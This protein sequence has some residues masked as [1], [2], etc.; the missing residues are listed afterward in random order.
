MLHSLLTSSRVKLKLALLLGCVAALT[1]A[2]FAIGVRGRLPRV[3]KPKTSGDISAQTRPRSGPVQLVQF[4]IY[5]VAIYPQEARVQKG[6]VA[7]SIED[8]TGSSSGLIIDRVEGNERARAGVVNR[9]MN[10]LRVRDEFFLPP[11][12]YEVSD[13]SRPDNRAELIVEP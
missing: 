13:A 2:V 1:T 6:R 12:H 10:R 7:V 8:L 5:D 9:A 4:T 3:L 11:G